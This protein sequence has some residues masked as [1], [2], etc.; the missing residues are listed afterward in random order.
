MSN[1]PSAFFFFGGLFVGSWVGYVV[2]GGFFVTVLTFT[3]FNVAGMVTGASGSR[4]MR[5]DDAGGIATARCCLRTT[6][7]DKSNLFCSVRFLSSSREGLGVIAGEKKRIRVG[8][9]KR[10]VMPS[11][12]LFCATSD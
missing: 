3:L 6:K 5:M 11:S 7:R 8:Y 12:H 9:R 1:F 10:N 4:M 2:G